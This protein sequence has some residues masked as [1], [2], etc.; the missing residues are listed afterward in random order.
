MNFPYILLLMLD[1]MSTSRVTLEVVR[2]WSPEYE[3]GGE[4]SVSGTTT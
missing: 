3:C 2:T 4:S 1:G